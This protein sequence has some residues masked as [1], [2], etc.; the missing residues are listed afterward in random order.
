MDEI[1]TVSSL[2]NSNPLVLITSRFATSLIDNPNHDR[3]D[4]TFWKWLTWWLIRVRI[5]IERSTNKII[6]EAA[7]RKIQTNSVVRFKRLEKKM[8]NRESI[9]IYGSAVRSLFMV[10]QAASHIWDN[11]VMKMVKE[12][13]LL[14]KPSLFGGFEVENWK[15]WKGID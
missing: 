15:I 11:G 6:C 7:T 10:K 13:K 9:I 8:E 5:I 12:E 1:E 4:I 3:L 2:I 14:V